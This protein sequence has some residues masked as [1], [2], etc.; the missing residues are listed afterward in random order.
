MALTGRE[1]DKGWVPGKL[2]G[3]V[4]NFACLVCY[5]EE[6]FSCEEVQFILFCLLLKATVM[7]FQVQTSMKLPIVT[8][9]NHAW[10][11]QF[12]VWSLNC[13]NLIQRVLLLNLQ[14]Q[15]LF[16]E[17]FFNS[18]KQSFPVLCIDQPL[19]GGIGTV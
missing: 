5:L 12:K 19:E 7:T 17:T 3:S 4:A 10:F 1:R 14:V 18:N 2:T 16:E 6:M 8:H 15:V 13:N 9:F 11:L